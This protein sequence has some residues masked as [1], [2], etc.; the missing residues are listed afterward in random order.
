MTH[1]LTK[2]SAA[3]RSVLPAGHGQ[4][5]WDL[6]QQY[7]V[8]LKGGGGGLASLFA[9]EDAA[10]WPTRWSRMGQHKEYI[11]FG[12]ATTRI[13]LKG[14]SHIGEQQSW[15]LTSVADPDDF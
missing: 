12:S 15:A 9:P 3:E 8:L 11:F 4:Q 7:Q 13:S 2:G 6:C 10:S 1:Q 5:Q 14:H